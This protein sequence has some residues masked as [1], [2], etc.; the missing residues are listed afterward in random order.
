M[1]T[2]RY[3]IIE[4]AQAEEKKRREIEDLLRRDDDKVEF[5]AIM[6]A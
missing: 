5:M 1:E 3:Q 6:T 2:P 4:K